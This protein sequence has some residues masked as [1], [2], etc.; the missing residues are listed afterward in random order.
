MR[1]AG[2]TNRPLWAALAVAAIAAG[3]TTATPTE[4]PGV[5]RA[6]KTVLHYKG[7]QAEVVLS[8]RS[9]GLRLGEDWLFLDVA[10]TGAGR[11]A[12]EIKRDRIALRVPS[13]EIV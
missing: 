8:Y 5:E 11:A 6:G 3:C 10:I 2:P 4:T 7:P 12:V 1:L 13:G 9:A